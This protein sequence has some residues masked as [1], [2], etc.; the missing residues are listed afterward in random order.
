MLPEVFAVYMYCNLPY[1]VGRR[2]NGLPDNWIA[3]FS[4]E[5]AASS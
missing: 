2:T 4:V 1:V 5:G 3:S